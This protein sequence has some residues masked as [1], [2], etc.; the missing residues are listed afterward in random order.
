VHAAPE[1]GWDPAADERRHLDG[2]QQ[3]EADDAPRDRNR[4]P[5]RRERHQHVDG[6]EAHVAVGD[7][8]GDVHADE[9][10]RGPAEEPVQIEQPC[11]R[12]PTAEEAGRQGDAPQR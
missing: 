3:V 10:Q 5:R 6:V 11:R 9:H 2:E 4:S 1:H 8:A 7:E 12:H